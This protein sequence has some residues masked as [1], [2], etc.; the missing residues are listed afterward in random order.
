MGDYPFISSDCT[1]HRR[2]PRSLLR[3]KLG[4]HR[5]TAD[6]GLADSD[7]HLRAFRQ[8]DIDAAAEADQPEALAGANAS[9]LAQESHDPPRDQPGDQHHAEPPALGSLD[10]KR[11][12]LVLLA[13]LVELGIEELARHVDAS[14]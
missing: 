8:I 1:R 13:G 12:A 2:L 6:R 5:L 14:A 11:A 3:R 9:P 4:Q 10:D 7:Q